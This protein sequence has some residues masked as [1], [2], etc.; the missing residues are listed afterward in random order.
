MTSL[1]LFALIEHSDIGLFISKQDHMVGAIAQLLHITGLILVLSSVLIVSL[2]LVG[3]G[4]RAL[5]SA[6]LAATTGKFVWI[7]LG[8][9]LVSGL[10][11]FV[12]AALLYH[13]NTFFRV[14]FLLLALALVVHVTLYRKVAQSNQVGTA[15]SWTTAVVSLGLWFGIAIMGRFIGFF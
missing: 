12:P 13:P 7:G 9:L 1:E 5:S 2:R 4:P 10:V 6:Q 11:M 14:K 3:Q 15:L 8:L